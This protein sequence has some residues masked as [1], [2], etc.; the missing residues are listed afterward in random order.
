MAIYLFA[1]VASFIFNAL[2][3]VPFIDLLYRLKFQRAK[4]KTRDAFNRRTPI[5]DKFNAHKAGTPVG[6]GILL[7][8]TTFILFIFFTLLFIFFK[9]PI[10]SNYQ[11][12]ASEIKILLFTFVF[13]SFLGLYDDLAKIFLWRKTAF[14]GLRLRHKLIIEII[15]ASIIAYWLFAEL[16]VSFIHIPFLGVFELS[17]FYIIFAIFVIISFA[18]AVNITD[19]LDG[20]SSGV[21]VIC[22]A[23][24]WAISGSILDTPLLVFIATWLGGLIAFLYFNI[25]PARLFLGDSGALSFGAT[26]AVIGLIS[27]KS[28]ALLI[29]GGIFVLEITSSFIQLVGKKFLKRRIL[30]VAPLHLLL[31]LRGW[32]EPK[33]VMRAWIISVMFAL[34]GLMVALMK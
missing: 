28:F 20:L 30:S 1:T 9:I 22:L 3:I 32:E 23:A 24:F 29:I 33:I 10:T 34:F 26:L 17:Y 31:R 16:K 4:Q 7:V 6:G 15:L 18:N 21:M 19:G 14:F 27:G 8:A 11:S 12:V 2:L 13:F 5:F 25:F